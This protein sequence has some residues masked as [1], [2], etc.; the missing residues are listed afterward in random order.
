VA[1]HSVCDGRKGRGCRRLKNALA[2]W[3]SFGKET[4]EIHQTSNLGLQSITFGII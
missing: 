1:C 3:S 2:Y 4:G